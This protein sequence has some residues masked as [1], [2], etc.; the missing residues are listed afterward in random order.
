MEFLCLVLKFLHFSN[1][2]NIS[3]D[4]YSIKQPKG[5]EN[6]SFYAKKISCFRPLIP[7]MTPLIKFI[8][9]KCFF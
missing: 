6:H 2:I 8:Q 1:L 7:E 9:K 5:V 4:K 3:F